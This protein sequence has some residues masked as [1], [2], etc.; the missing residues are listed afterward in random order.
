MLRNQWQGT[1]DNDAG[2][3]TLAFVPC[4]A[5]LTAA[6]TRSMGSSV[7]VGNMGSLRISG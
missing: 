7:T 6:A 5:S 2:N 1:K 4:V 3:A